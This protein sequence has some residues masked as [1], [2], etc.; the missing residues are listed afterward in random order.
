MKIIYYSIIMIIFWG[1]GKE[2]PFDNGS[3]VA[4]T[5]FFSQKAGAEIY[6]SKGLNA[7]K[8]YYYKD[9]DSI[10]NINNASASL[11]DEN[12]EVL[13]LYF[14]GNGKYTSKDTNWIPQ[15]NSKYKIVVSVPDYG[16]VESDFV[17]YPMEAKVDSLN[18]FK[19]EVLVGLSKKIQAADITLFMNPI[20]KEEQFYEIEY[21]AVDSLNS[22]LY[23]LFILNNYNSKFTKVERS[24][25]GVS[26]TFESSIFPN[27]CLKDNKIYDLIGLEG[28]SFGKNIVSAFVKQMNIKVHSVSNS[29]HKQR[30]NA[31]TIADIDERFQEVPATYTNIKNGIGY[32]Y[33]K[34]EGNKV[35]VVKR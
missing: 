25:C 22:S 14:V 4:V 24:N 1:C 16:I 28:V 10:F 34:N 7:S 18:Y 21:N 13:K 17:I 3:T 23:E 20:T 6:L 32:F 30:L 5:G 27:S 29:R 33:A 2:N 15:V 11:W 26:Y 19:K 8:T 31:N 12:K 9:V 35:F